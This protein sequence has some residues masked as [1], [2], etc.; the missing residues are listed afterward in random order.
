MLARVVELADTQCSER[1]SLLMGVRVQIP[2]LAPVFCYNSGIK[3]G[4][5]AELVYAQR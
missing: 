1:C 4:R 2:P 3:P 5:V